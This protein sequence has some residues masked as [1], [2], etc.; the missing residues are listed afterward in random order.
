MTVATGAW[1]WLDAAGLAVV[2]GGLAGAILGALTYLAPMLRGGGPRQRHVIR[3]RAESLPRLRARA[4][5]V[6]VGLLVVAA[7]GGSELGVAGAVAARAGWTVLL[8]SGAVAA[9]AGWTVLLA[10]VAVH[11]GLLAWPVPTTPSGRPSDRATPRS[12]G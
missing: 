9:R 10:S 4:V 5:A 6:S 1:R 3:R 11:V 12:S 2:V 8:A 7:A